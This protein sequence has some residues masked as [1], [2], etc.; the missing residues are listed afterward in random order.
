MKII[1]LDVGI[2]NMAVCVLEQSTHFESNNEKKMDIVLW[3]ILNVGTETVPVETHLCSFCR[4]KAV[5]RNANHFF[6]QKH[7][8]TEWIPV[9]NFTKLSNLELDELWSR[10][11]PNIVKPVEWSFKQLAQHIKQNMLTK[12]VVEKKVKASQMSLIDI[13]RKM[14]VLLDHLLSNHLDLTHVLIENQIS[15]IATRMKTLQGMLAQYFIIRFPQV[16]IEFVSSHNKLTL[17]HPNTPEIM[18]NNIGKE[19]IQ[20]G[21]ETEKKGKKKKEVKKEKE[22]K[23]ENKENKYRQN[24][25]QAVEKVSEWVKG[26]PFEH[27]FQESKKKDDLA[28]CLLQGLW[29][30]QVKK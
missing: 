10:K 27:F 15:P 28:D 23:K 29:F 16:S 3:D 18:E 26:G 2:K 22:E 19:P 5:Y 12:C 24:K 1:S 17:T 14:T 20:T 30:V 11:N 7:A 25:K 21:N 13:G 6:C 4:K 9:K 8:Q